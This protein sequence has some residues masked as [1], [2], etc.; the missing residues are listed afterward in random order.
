MSAFRNLFS[1]LLVAGAAT[2]GCGD[3][4]Q[5]PTGGTGASG[6][7]ASGGSGGHAH[8]GG[9]STGAAGGSGG[10]GATGGMTGG[11]GGTPECTVAADCGSSDECRF[12]SCDGGMCNESFAA[13]G[14]AVLAQAASDCKLNVCDGAGAVISE[15]DNSDV[16][17]DLNEC[18]SNT[19]LDGVPTNDPLPSGTSCGQNGTFYCDGAKNCVE[20][21]VNAHCQSGICGGGNICAPASCGDGS[22]NGSETDVDCGG[23][24]CG[25]CAVGKVCS[26]GS[27]CLDGVCD[28]NTNT[29]KAAA[30]NDG[31]KNAQESD[32]DCGGPACMDCAPGKACAGAADCTSG[33]CSG[34]PLTCQ[35]PICTD[36]VKNGNE[37]DVDCGGP[38][39]PDCVNGKLC[40]VGGDCVSGVCSGNPKVCQVPTCSDGTKNGTETGVDCGSSCPDCPNG[41]GC[42]MNTDCISGYCNAQN[43]CAAPTCMDGAKNGAETDVD[44]GGGTCPDCVDGKTCGV[45]DDCVGAFCLGPPICQSML[46]G[47][48]DATAVDQTGVSMTTITQSGF[49]YIPKCLKIKAGTQVTINSSFAGHPLTQGPVVNNVVYPQV[50]GP[51]AHTQS[52]TTATFTFPT[53][54]QFGYYCDFHYSAGMSGAIFVVP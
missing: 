8:T 39:C 20:C 11:S 22:K 1:I 53:V 40:S 7:G 3:N 18:T 46:N 30:C 52:G 29:C 4:E 35:Q 24:V 50:G 48:T 10:T 25:K 28:M 6:T 51:I 21:L 43:I 19:C 49:D 9:M 12:F 13:E 45:A 31:V 47:C 16:F 54:G 27:D 33:V 2:L 44:C 37:T 34:N 15:E 38:Q 36:V 23:P 17:D 26:A 32:V 14:T 5:P 41:Q 42:A